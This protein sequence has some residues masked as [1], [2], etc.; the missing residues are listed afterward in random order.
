VIDELTLLNKQALNRAEAAET[1]LKIYK[2]F[3]QL[4]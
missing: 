2:R 4:W 3:V 1:E